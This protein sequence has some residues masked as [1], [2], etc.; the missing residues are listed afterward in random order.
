MQ[1]P[2]VVKDEHLAC[3]QLALNQ[4]ARAFDQC[5][6][7]AD[8]ALHRRHLREWNVQGGKCAVG[9]VDIDR[10]AGRI[11]LDD[12]VARIK[13]AFGILKAKGEAGLGQDIKDLGF[14]AAQELG[15]C[16]PIRK[17]GRTAISAVHQAMQNLQS[18]WHFVMGKVRVERQ[19]V[20]C[21]GV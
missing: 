5:H 4:E 8:C 11:E 18:R 9:P 17:Q 10:V 13:L 21:I 15:Y 16:Q 3:A 7:A 2:A 6:E 14:R 1:H 12:W 19:I 20:G